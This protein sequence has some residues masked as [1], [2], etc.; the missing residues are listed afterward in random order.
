MVLLGVIPIIIP[1]RTSKSWSR[2]FFSLE[3]T[4]F[5]GLET[6]QTDGA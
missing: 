3:W 2:G 5:Q 4:K 1:N 6:Q